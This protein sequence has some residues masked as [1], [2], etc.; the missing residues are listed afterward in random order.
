MG[1]CIHDILDHE[2]LPYRLNGTSL[3]KPQKFKMAGMRSEED[4]T[5]ELRAER[6]VKC[7]EEVWNSYGEIGDAGLL[8]EWGFLGGEYAGEGLLWR[9]EEVDTKGTASLEIWGR[10][11]G[12]YAG[13]T[14][15]QAVDSDLE[16]LW[17]G[18][19]DEEDDGQGLI[20][21]PSSDTVGRSKLNLSLSGQLSFSLFLLVYL[22]ADP[23]EADDPPTDI[24]HDAKEA[25]EEIERAYAAVEERLS[26]E[27]ATPANA[28]SPADPPA[29]ALS[30]SALEC[31]HGVLDLLRRRTKA[32]YRSDL[33]S[34]E[35]LH[36]RDVSWSPL[37]HVR[38]E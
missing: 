9:A 14:G 35:V 36:L 10:V 15:S 2:G 7:G 28:E 16:N 21:P 34:D 32:M 37:F 11:I 18:E 33:S 12:V 6:E 3:S 13:E 27:D 20:S 25:A 17:A 1:R 23:P 4:D 30:S 38:I 22:A 8:A 5:V 24:L 29:K 26:A 31:V 19:G